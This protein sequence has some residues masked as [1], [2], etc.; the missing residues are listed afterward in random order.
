VCAGA[1]TRCFSRHPPSTEARLVRG[2][3]STLPTLVDAS[4]TTLA[5][6]V[7]RLGTAHECL[8][9]DSDPLFPS[10]DGGRG[11]M[12]APKGGAVVAPVAHTSRHRLVD[13]VAVIMN[14][15]AEGHS[16]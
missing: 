6:D 9:W 2:H 14:H 16:A 10:Q 4:P 5:D 8:G 12:V 13:V 15:V 11:M 1:W 3:S 7:S